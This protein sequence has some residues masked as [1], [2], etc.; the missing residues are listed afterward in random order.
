MPTITTGVGLN[1]GIDI[2][3]LVDSL[4]DVQRGQ[5]RRLEARADSFQA[6]QSAI[7][8]LEANLLT[9]SAAAQRLGESSTFE[10][11]TVTNTDAS[12]LE[13]STDSDV[14][15]GAY[16]FQGI[17]RSSTHQVRSKGFANA[18]QQ[19]IGAGTLT[20]TTG[21]GLHRSTLIDALN[22]GA[23][24]HRGSV[25]VT[26]RSGNSADIDLSSVHTVDDVLDAINRTSDI[27]VTAGTQDGRIVLSD[28]SGGTGTFSVSDLNGGS[29]AADLGIN[30]SAAA[31]TLSG[32]TV[33]YAADDFAL[34]QIDDGNGLYRLSGAPDLR[35][36]LT[37]DTTIDV[38]LDNTYTLRDVL[39]VIN[40]HADNGGKLSATLVD[41]RLQLTDLSGGGGTSA[42]A[43]EDINNTSVIR[44]L[45]LD[46]SASGDTITGHRLMA[47]MNSVLLR[48]LRGGQGIDQTGQMTL[49][50]RTGT[51]ATIDLTGAESLDEVLVAINN[52]QSG[53]GTDLQL[54]A[55]I[56]D[57]GTGIEVQDTSGAT[58]S[59]LVIADVGGSTLAA[60]LG[61]DVDAAQDSIDSGSL[62]LRR[63]NEATSLDDYAPDGGS[64]AEGAFTITDSAGNQQ[65]IT[66]TSAVETIGDVLVR[67]NSA[68]T[69]AVKAELNETGDGFVLIDEAGGSDPLSVVEAGG[70]TAADLRILGDGTLNAAGKS[71]ITSRHAMTVEISS[72]DTL[73]DIAEKINDAGGEVTAAV[74]DN[75]AAFNSTRLLLT[76][77]T[78]GSKGNLTID[79]GPLDLGLTTIAEGNDA[80]LRVGSNVETSFLIAS[81]DNTFKNA[82]AGVDVEVL[83]AASRSADVTITRNGN[84]IASVVDTFIQAYNTFLDTANDLTKFDAETNERGVL[85]GSGLVLR[86][87][88]R[89]D[90]LVHSR[91]TNFDNPIQ[92]LAELGVRP[93]ATG[94]LILDEDQLESAL[95][96]DFQAVADFFLDSDNGL[97]GRLSGAM[98]ALTDPFT[99]T[100][101]I[102]KD[103]LQDSV[104]TLNQRV[105]ELNAILEVRRE[106]MTLEFIQMEA[107]LGELSSQQQVISAITLIKAPS[108]SKD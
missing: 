50:D 3:G 69:I 47:G 73:N 77:T 8:I 49:T 53:G 67:I 54:A 81:D 25:R 36:T 90:S 12:Q 83:A 94:K 66:I 29:A 88:S 72:T 45:G 79:D 17:R 97:A 42:F 40:D 6:T 48:N 103:S 64:V 27:A 75:G 19:T 22:G 39:G 7:K 101:V 58:A 65:T 104:D 86:L 93:G 51:T 99:G 71:Q 92:S 74:F 38:N 102:E 70:T 18:D 46:A 68:A 63:M 9:F 26:D 76:S 60:Q 56:N 55:R 85:Q 16:Q 14:V 105:E 31:S 4:I 57:A 100:L 33:Y 80:L 15:P 61:I 11:V 108:S 95:E 59:N 78:A 24:I 28:T 84:K 41:G 20:I 98:D 52:A 82:A 35:V 106:R 23:G 34:E 96:D 89:L 37:D 32:E 44:Q 5:V 30:K 87:N 2:A 91:N 43:V 107:A 1:S 10:A 21:D 62:N 13:I